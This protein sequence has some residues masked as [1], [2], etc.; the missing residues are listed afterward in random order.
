MS[1][2]DSMNANLHSETD[3]LKRQKSALSLKMATLDAENQVG[4]IKN[5]SVSLENCTCT[6]FSRRH[7]P[8]K[9]MYR[10]AMDLGIFKVDNEGIKD[11]DNA[12]KPEKNIPRYPVSYE[13]SAYE[14]VPTDFVVIDF[15]TANKKFDSVCQMGLVKVENNS[16]VERKSFL[17]RP[18]YKK[19]ANSNIHGITFDDVKDAPDFAELWTEI[20][21]YIENQIVAAYN[22]FFDW[23]CLVA[24]LQHYDIELPEFKAFDILVNAR[25][26]FNSYDSDFP[27][28]KSCSL[29]N[30]ADIL[31]FQHKAHDAL[32]DSEVAA[33]IQIYLSKKFPN[34]EITLYTAK[35][36][37]IIDE[38]NSGKM[39][40]LQ[41]INYCEH[42]LEAK[43]ISYDDYKDFFKL[44]EQIAVQ[45]NIAELYKCCGIFYEKF[46][47]VP[48][49][50]FL[51]KK[52]LGLDSTMR[53]KT[54]IQKLEREQCKINS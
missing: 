37:T 15:E 35:L 48:R 17:I 8:C 16:I 22:L 12:P 50:I 52:A 38:I 34:M 7:K 45:K 21:K 36:L 5:Y 31:G 49:A 10:L 40:I 23:G 2:F 19:I 27:S 39:S 43:N 4:T 11:L 51:Y 33:E 14:K 6:D 3:Q 41:I 9:H 26:Y 1:F 44:V 30:V 32:S 28:L 53:L 13:Y 42:L 46:N 54:K 24:T 20:K 25:N 29:V 47:R 18:P